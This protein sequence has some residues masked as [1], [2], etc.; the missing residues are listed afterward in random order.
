MPLTIQTSS[1]FDE[2]KKLGPP[3]CWL[4]GFLISLLLSQTGC[5]IFHRF[6]NDREAAPIVFQQPPNQH[7]LIAHLNSQA[8]KVKQLKTNVRVSV[9]GMPTLRGSLAVERPKRL[10]LKAGLLGVS[11]LG[12]DVGSNDQHFWVWTK[13]SLPGETPSIYYASHEGYRSSSIRRALPMDPAWIIDALGFVNFNP[14]DRHDGPFE[15]ADGRYEIRS[16]IQS[17][18]GPTA[19]ISVIDPKHGWISQQSIYDS[20]GQLVAYVDSIK[21]KTYPSVG[22]S[23][24]QRFEIHVFQSD[25]Q[26]MKLVVDADDYTVNSLYGDPDKLWAMPNPQDIPKV[27]LAQVQA[28]SGNKSQVPPP[29]NG[30]IG[31]NPFGRRR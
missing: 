28:V 24:P 14:A 10:R 8:D 30:N 20:N 3:R 16:Y 1:K 13:A 27:D 29:A 6:R 23:L 25:G 12:V 22:I 11:E 5:Q 19:R 7:E 31:P 4:V 17:A 2:L 18:S 21:H 15:R 26:E 9:D